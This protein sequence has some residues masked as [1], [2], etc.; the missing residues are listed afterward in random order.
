MADIWEKILLIFAGNFNLGH[1]NLI[2]TVNFEKALMFFQKIFPTRCDAMNFSSHEIKKI[3][4]CNN[5][6]QR[7]KYD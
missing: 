7:K 6:P 1:S 3:A 4:S 2:T 5:A